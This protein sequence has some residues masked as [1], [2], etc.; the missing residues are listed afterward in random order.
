MS[1]CI[2]MQMSKRHIKECSLLLSENVNQNHSKRLSKILLV[3]SIIKIWAKKC[4]SGVWIW[5]KGFVVHGNIICHSYYGKWLENSLKT[6]VVTTWFN[7]FSSECGNEMRTDVICLCS[8]SL[9]C[10]SLYQG[11]E[12]RLVSAN[13]WVSSRC[14]EGIQ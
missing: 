2:Y 7:N 6:D 1:R 14:R 12:A 10:Y 5:N 9:Q 4:K 8:C 3:C 13:E 11:K